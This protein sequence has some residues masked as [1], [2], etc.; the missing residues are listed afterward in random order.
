MRH[1]VAQ[2]ASEL[3]AEFG[4]TTASASEDPRDPPGS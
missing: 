2:A 1:A 3:S 4:A